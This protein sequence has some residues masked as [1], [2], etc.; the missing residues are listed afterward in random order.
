MAMRYDSSSGSRYTLRVGDAERD[1]AVSQL[2]EHF[3]AGR[4]TMDEFIERIDAA[5]TAKTHADLSRLMADLPRLRWPVRVPVQRSQQNEDTGIVARYSAI[6]LL[7]LLVLLW[8]TAVTL[9]FHHGYTY[10]GPGGFGH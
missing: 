2:Q 5:L 10:Q 7:A 6:V 4:L 3:A 9:L 1:E 8:M